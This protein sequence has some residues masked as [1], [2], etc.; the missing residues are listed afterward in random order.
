MLSRQFLSWADTASAGERADAARDLA[1]AFLYA[2]IDRIEQ[3]EMERAMTAL[4]DDPSP[5]VRRTLAEALAGAAHAP[6]HMVSALA[7]DQADI[8]AIVL[9]RSPILT[10][11]EL[12]DAAAVSEPAGQCAIASR[13]GLSAAVAGAL[14][15]VGSLDAVLVLCRNHDAVLADV[16]VRRILERFGRDGDVRESLSARPDLEAALR[17]DLVV[18]TADA[19]R[20]FVVDCLWMAPERARR[21]AGEASERATMALSEQNDAAEG[22]LGRLRF[23]GHL[24]RSGHLTPALV[25]RALFSG[26][27][28]LFETA[29][30]ELSGQT[31]SRVAGLVRHPD[32][33]AF[34]ALVRAASLPDG[35]L[36]CI[37][38]ALSVQ[39]SR[40]AEGP[41]RLRREIV[42]EVLARCDM[43]QG[44]TVSG[45]TALMRRFEAEAAREESR[46]APVPQRASPA[47]RPVAFE[48]S[49]RIEP[50]FA[51]PL[52][53]APLDVSPLDL[54]R[55]EVPPEDVQPAE[56]AEAA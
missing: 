6:H 26:Q 10:E 13:P 38:V 18:A 35:L 47:R 2:D 28:A 27:L 54:P 56:L 44:S 17:H 42:G 36:P 19:L 43:A 3:G 14:A 39:P 16:S 40:S 50:A 49:R 20:R 21:V 22:D 12:I 45:L 30:A 33:L 1:R 32:G 4:L 8:A 52:T 31:L 25:L 41:A 55:L 5:L 51:E 7:S 37:R 34:A 9:A 46:A 15:E 29:L 48:L 23:V 53:P 11:S 24:R